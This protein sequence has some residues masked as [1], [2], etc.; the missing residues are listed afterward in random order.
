M[1][2][3]SQSL[4]LCS[5][6]VSLEQPWMVCVTGYSA[7]RFIAIQH[8][9]EGCCF[10]SSLTSSFNDN[11]SIKPNFSM[12][13][14]RLPRKPNPLNHPR[15]CHL[16]EKTIIQ[17]LFWSYFVVRCKWIYFMK[18]KS[19]HFCFK[20]YISPSS[21][22]LIH[23]NVINCKLKA[24]NMRSNFMVLSFSVATQLSNYLT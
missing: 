9:I 14:F 1:A 2:V 12:V 15:G 20:T 19:W 21:Y 17:K 6:M 18:K 7:Q 22:Y 5:S 8:S 11:F 23:G 4:D 24:N 16:H 10:S 3:R 13:I